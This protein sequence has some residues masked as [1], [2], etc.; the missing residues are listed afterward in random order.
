MVKEVTSSSEYRDCLNVPNLVVVDYYASWCGPCRN[1]APFVEQ[2][3]NK[4]P[5]V[6]FLKVGEHHC[7]DVIMSAGVSAFPTFQ[8][9]IKSEKIDEMRGANPHEL[10][11]KVLEHRGKGGGE[12]FAGRGVTLGGNG[13]NGVGYPPDGNAREARLKAFGH[14]DEKPQSSGIPVN[15]SVPVTSGDDEDE[16]IAKAIALSMSA[17]DDIDASSEKTA[18][19]NMSRD[20]MEQQE[21]EM[22]PV[23]VNEEMLAQLLEMDIPEVRARKGLV[24]GGTVEGA[25]SWIAENQDDP[26]IDQPYMVRKSEAIPRTPLTDEERATKVQ[27]MKEKAARLKRE[28]EE[29]EKQDA[30]IREK[31]RRE[32]GQKLNQ[33]QEERDRMMRKIEA[34]KIKREKLEAKRERERLRAEIARDKELRRANNGVLPSVLGA[35][36]Y[37]PSALK[38]DAKDTSA[39]HPAS[40]TKVAAVKEKAIPVKQATHSATAPP[41]VPPAETIDTAINTISRYRTGGDGGNALRLLLLFLK[42]IRDNPSEEKYRSVNM[43][44]KAYKSKLAPLVGPSALLKAVGFV[45]NSSDGKLNY[46][47]DDMELLDSTISK[48]SEAEERYRQMNNC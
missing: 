25:V 4:Y 28:R 29:K 5:D 41:G 19:E 15:P 43:E 1:I 13:W 27:E 2:L 47:G 23:P 7:R 6:V 39:E 30:I 10:E 42:N 3:S 16:A 46:T 20:R 40:T 17:Q 45:V 8:F 34:E 38:Y 31:E 48:L 24:H 22:V 26:N 32:R 9:F 18:E 21:E 14:I 44:S 35:E 36:G 12:A 37:N 33:T 11:K